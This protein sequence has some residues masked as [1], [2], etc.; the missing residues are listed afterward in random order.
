VVFDA[1]TFEIW[2]SL[3]NGGRLV[4]YEA[5]IPTLE[6]IG[7][8]LR[9]KQVTVL[10]LTAGLFQQ[11][12]EQE[13]ESLR[14]VR[15]LLAG[16]DVL[17]VEA[18][19]RALGAGC[20]VINGY[21]PTENTTFTCCY[22]VP[23]EGWPGTTVPIGAPI[24]CT[25]VYVLDEY[26]EP[27][28]VGVVGELYMGG[29]GLARGYQGRAELTAEKFIP[30]RFSREGGERL[31]RSGDRVRWLGE[32]VLEF[33][34]RRDD[35]V[36]VRGFR[37]ELREIE[38]V[39]QELEE[40]EQAVVTV[41]E[42]TAAGKQL[43][44]YVVPRRK[45]PELEALL[46]DHLQQKLPP[47]MLPSVFVEMETLPLSSNGKVARQA[48]PRPS[49]A[50]QPMTR[51]GRDP[52]EEILA[53]IW[54]DVLGCSSI[55]REDD[56]FKLGG[57]SLLAMKIVSRIRE[58]LRTTIP[59]RAVFE[60][61]TIGQMAE[62]IRTS[63]SAQS[64]Q[65]ARI[66]RVERGKPL[67]ASFAQQRL[68]FLQQYEP[69]TVH[70]NVPIR[71][72]F[73]GP[74]NV[75]AFAQAVNKI[76]R[77]HEA[78]RTRFTLKDDLP[79]Q[80]IDAPPESTLQIADL[81]AV[82]A[83]DREHHLERIGAE[84]GLRPFD[85]GNGPLL[86]AT[87]VVLS[88]QEHV[89]LLTIHHAAIDAW[90]LEIFA[91]EL[92]TL[93]GYFSG[94][95]RSTLPEPAIQY[96]DFAVWQRQSIR[97][98]VL[99]EQLAYW[100]GQLAGLQEME[101]PTAPS[102]RSRRSHAGACYDFNLA[103]GLAGL[104]RET[105]RC[106]GVTLLMAAMAAVKALLYRY[107]GQSDIAIGTPIAGRNRAELE[108]LIGLFLNMIVL[109]TTVSGA[110]GFQSLLRSVRDVALPAY[111]HQDA[112]F[113]KLVEELQ[114][115]RDPDGSMLFQVMLTV[116]SS[117]Q[118][119]KLAGIDATAEHIR[120]L[121][122]KFDLSLSLTCNG[123]GL[124]GCL[125][126]RRELFDDL[127]IARMSGHL[128]R[129]LSYACENP[130]VPVDDL[131]LLG[132]AE[133]R[134][135]L[136]QWNDTSTTVQPGQSLHE[137]FAEQVRR[138][139]QR[140]AIVDGERHVT[141][142][143]LNRMA[144]WLARLL[145]QEKVQPEAFVGICLKR[146]IEMA[147]SM[148]AVL[149][150]GAAYVPLDPQYPS[151]RLKHIIKDSGLRM[152]ITT[153]ALKERVL[154]EAVS[155]LL[156]DQCPWDALEPK[157]PDEHCFSIPNSA[158]YVIYTSGSSGVPKGVVGLQGS[159][160]NRLAWQWN[161]YP[162]PDDEACCLK[163]P[164]GFV[165]SVAELFGPLLQG[166]RLIVADDPTVLDLQVFVELLT[167]HGVTR[168]TVV[169]AFLRELL[170]HLLE[171]SHSPRS[172]RI[173]VSSGEA[174]AGD[175]AD[176]FAVA[177]PH[178]TLLNFY[179]S[180]EVAADAT[181]AKLSGEYAREA[182]TIGQPVANV[183]VYV[184]D[185]R[186]NPA[187]IG[188]TGEICVGGMGLARGYLHQPDLTADRFIPDP[189]CGMPGSRMYR[190]G[191]LGRW[192]GNGELEFAGRRDLQVKVRGCRIELSEV[193]D[194]I[195]KHQSVQDAVVVVT[196]D[197]RLAAFLVAKT[198]GVFGTRD[199]RNYLKARLPDY[200]VPSSIAWL[201]E[202]PLTA[203]GKVDRRA[204]FAMPTRDLP[205]QGYVEPQTHTQAVLAAIWAD[206]LKLERVGIHDDY[207]D[208][209]GNSLLAMRL[210][211]RT[212]RK[213]HVD[214]PLSA[215]F[216]EPTVAQLSHRIDAAVRGSG[217]SGTAPITRAR[218]N[219]EATLSFLQEGYLLN[220]W[221]LNRRTGRPLAPFNLAFGVHL[222]G[223]L[224]VTALQEA[225][226]EVVK[227]HEILRTTFHGLR[228]DG[229][230]DQYLS[231]IENA[232]KKRGGG[233]GVPLVDLWGTGL[234]RAALHPHLQ[235]EISIANVEELAAE[236]RYPVAEEVVMSN[237][238]SLIDFERPPLLHPI[239]VK[240]D[241]DHHLFAIVIHHVIADP[242]ALRTL[243][244]ELLQSYSDHVAGCKSSLPELEVQYSDFA[245][246]ERNR[247]QG[248]TLTRMGQDW[249][250]QW[251]EFQADFLQA[252]HF[253]FALPKPKVA[254]RDCG[255]EVQEF[256]LQGSLKMSKFARANHITLHI[257]C[258]AAWTILAHS[259][260]GKK[261]IAIW[262]NFANRTQ[263]ET[264]DMIGCF[265]SSQIIGL[266]VSDDPTVFA[267]L[268]RARDVLLARQANQELTPDLAWTT[269]ITGMDSLASFPP[270]GPYVRLET[271]MSWEQDLF[272]VRDLVA[273]PARFKGP[274]AGDSLSLLLRGSEHALELLVHYSIGWFKAE[275]IR[276]LLADLQRM[277]HLVIDTP[278]VHLSQLA[279]ACSSSNALG[280]RIEDLPL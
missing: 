211:A 241:T 125:H 60:F 31:Y 89:F 20:E 4:V 121:P 96:A 240:L 217:T 203:S 270:D 162:F 109:R 191:D 148:L 236:D 242:L 220:L 69:S 8:V 260:T 168:I 202:L 34:G 259:Y 136:V 17:G 262:N 205:E 102:R 46:R 84:H 152:V 88:A 11:M 61:P 90:S 47:Y 32:G 157:L 141:Y 233:T 72:R 33:C 237:A 94:A 155:Y 188:V 38:A 116:N 103:P 193:E 269:L 172:M 150:T 255:L 97:G 275:D 7:R 81:Q 253:P 23:R 190:T 214:L 173:I 39:L 76:V 163:T 114:P 256:G 77:R 66:G 83:P 222:Y 48:L 216:A 28:P 249:K 174:L 5:G 91:N 251:D 42:D 26:L 166:I 156:L 167:I 106:E 124:Q 250:T 56:F 115:K 57:H 192:S 44:A 140:V 261:R 183:K 165:D 92:E 147:V 127:T 54:A 204:V 2:G 86:W 149:K 63:G 30:N 274:I 14:G 43:V 22:R 231:L 224:N 154:A 230:R 65:A 267:L 132:E 9:E 263:A 82:P 143:Q 144:N 10:W 126:Y 105:A 244:K 181:C 178:V 101:L 67:P 137:L 145:R 51:I 254:V 110:L 138:T 235:V 161:A 194:V 238:R 52:T 232:L 29:R 100:R 184:L 55:D 207:F 24:N 215:L 208:Y 159:T 176:M 187:S 164:V 53:G 221:W 71:V 209:G 6:G 16:G 41:R 104:L 153:D 75:P 107:S 58:A 87:L 131:P 200:M 266:D 195:R 227:R 226:N 258:L 49:L 35:Q 185:A 151:E 160:V 169:P 120:N 186:L 218:R 130:M 198:K 3:L 18:V 99:E 108:G 273:E 59:I 175:L 279:G 199:V 243:Q 93:Y 134:Q 245:Q 13:R 21:G 280:L 12:V 80:L 219:G 27:V 119:W 272:K 247:L 135:V 68:Y 264:Q 50:V 182:V 276:T 85:L 95:H 171:S 177:L 179:G 78:L 25:E 45:I 197:N 112:P 206:V 277:I 170:G 271:I 239:L 142:Q 265:A 19:R 70:Y 1:S 223:D 158:A 225:V 268:Q 133:R 201:S 79:I 129:L 196:E 117:Q 252:N 229:I 234:F 73:S 40:V 118:D 228:E 189:F 37:I 180:S 139:P 212:S 111:A 213:F 257:L 64:L 248:E 74:L 246:W 128:Q 210:M 146:S 15:E 62:K 113:E 36:K 278:D 98:A 123:E 122:A